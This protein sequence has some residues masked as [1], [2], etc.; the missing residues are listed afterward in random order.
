MC[1]CVCVC[2]C[3]YIYIYIER[4]REGERKREE[5]GKERENSQICTDRYRYDIA[6]TNKMFFLRIHTQVIVE[7]GRNKN[8]QSKWIP[9]S[10]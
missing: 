1:V 5:W 2:V 3:I 7:A 9:S 6:W 8:F 4:E 10:F